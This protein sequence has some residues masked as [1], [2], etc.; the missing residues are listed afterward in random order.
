MNPPLATH[1]PASRPALTGAKPERR[2]QRVPM[3]ASSRGVALIIVMVAI[4][5]LSVLAGAF[6]YSMKV[7][8]KLAQNA[9]NGSA[10]IWLG[11]SGVE[12]ACYVL[13]EQT[14]VRAE[15]YDALNQKW[16][17]GPGGF[18][19]SNSPLASISLDD[20]RVGDGTLSIKITDL[21]RRINVN[22]ADEPLLQQALTQMGVEA[23]EIPI[24]ADSILDWIDP[25]DISRINGAESDYYDGQQPPYFA[26]NGPVDDLAELLLV[27]GV[28]PE[29]Y[30]GP[31]AAS[32]MPAAFQ[33]VDR[34]GRAIAIP[35][36]AAGLVDVFTPISSG[37]ININTASV[38]TL[39]MLPGM[40]EN[41]AAQVVS[42]RS[43]PDGAEGTEDDTPFR[44][45]GELINAGLPRAAI[46]PLQRFC[47]V[48]SRTFEV[49]VNAEIGGSKSTFHAIVVRNGPRD[50]KV[51]SFYWK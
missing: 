28:T 50:L 42:Q 33:R 14:T 23:S 18:A 43:G 2:Q 34:F 39:Q 24:V 27:R 6:A 1:R 20:V 12:Y 17:G 45:V 15:P 41:T 31:A 36:Y 49:Q 26:K 21:E 29:M 5:V 30:W 38:T 7:E 47:D 46:Q 16:A 25:D 22:V 3:P 44:N 35:T 9:N 11:R 13:A 48:R 8:M 4:F 19:S 10:L 37:K 32:H 40:D 51:A